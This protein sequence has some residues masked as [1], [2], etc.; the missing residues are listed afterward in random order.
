MIKRYFVNENTGEI[1]E[2]EIKKEQRKNLDKK[3]AKMAFF[4]A[5]EVEKM[6]QE[7]NHKKKNINNAE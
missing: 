4:M 6:S 5:C 3:L 1:V 2:G 7:N